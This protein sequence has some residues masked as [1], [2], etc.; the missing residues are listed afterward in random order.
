VADEL[1][2]TRDDHQA[3]LAGVAP[4]V[5]DLTGILH[6]HGIPGLKVKARQRL[7]LAPVGMHQPEFVFPRDGS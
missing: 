4:V 2:P 5:S 3:D 6:P 7:L 1:D